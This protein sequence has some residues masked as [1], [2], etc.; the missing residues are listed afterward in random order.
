[1]L[2][3]PWSIWV[4]SIWSIWGKNISC[5]EERTGKRERK[6]Q[7]IM[8]NYWSLSERMAEYVPKFSF[9]CSFGSL[10]TLHS[11][12]KGMEN[13]SGGLGGKHDYSN[14]L[15]EIEFLFYMGKASPSIQC[16]ASA[17]I[18]TPW[19]RRMGTSTWPA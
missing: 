5:V 11:V 12:Q 8:L 10:M 14:A 1:M 15:N 6:D 9:G 4:W 13:L 16:T 19:S 7:N 3:G 17:T 18:L 2:E